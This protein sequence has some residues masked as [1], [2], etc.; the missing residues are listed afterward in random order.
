MTRHIVGLL[1]LSLGLVAGACS[2][3]SAPSGVNDNQPA[4][5]RA[6]NDT[7][8]TGTGGKPGGGP[9]GSAGGFK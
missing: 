8:V 3:A 4:F 1:I 9:G 6:T 2:D 5:K 7:T